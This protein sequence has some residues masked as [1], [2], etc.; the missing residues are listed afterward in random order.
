MRMLH[1]VLAAGGL[2]L[3]SVAWAHQTSAPPPVDSPGEIVQL[4]ERCGAFQVVDCA[5]EVLTGQPLHL[6][7]GSLAPQDGFGAGLAYVGHKTTD[8]WRIHWDADGL[9]STK[10][11]RVGW[12]G[13]FVHSTEAPT[14]SHV[15]TDM[16]APDTPTELPEHLVVTLT[17]QAISL[18]DVGFFGLG[19][20]TS[21]DGEV[22][23]GMRQTILGAAVVKPF[24]SS[25]HPTLYG[26]TNGRFVSIRAPA[27]APDLADS[28][29]F[30][31]L[32]E[33]VRLRPTF[34]RRLVELNYDVSFREYIAPADSTFTF[35]RLTVDLTHDVALHFP[36]RRRWPQ[37]ANGPDECTTGGDPKHPFDC[38][39][40]RKVE[41]T[42]EV[43][44][45]LSD[46]FTPAGHVVP[47]YLQPTLGG[48]DIN[49]EH[50]LASY[51]DY[52]FRAPNV[53][54]VRLGIEH[55]IFDLPIGV[56]ALVDTGRVALTRG[57]LTTGPWQNSVSAGLTV[58]AGGIPA[59][60]LLY[61]RGGS[62]GG[63]ASLLVSTTLLGGSSRP[64]LY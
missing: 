33:G 10:G 44:A 1:V 51:Q 61:A 5:S 56:I 28:R 58:R 8:A 20:S 63:H 15:G 16:P 64:S 17:A 11:W 38:T 26:E 50:A 32:A 43:R 52:R 23:F 29:T 46:A 18:D 6:T 42:V 40:T 3:P 48:A 60:S 41:G 59:L 24:T 27:T 9:A 39:I 47:F 19:P 22:F 37:D 2:L 62:E 14:T 54:F 57:A 25:W 7:I 53:M 21:P 55:S 13:K 49:G 12:Y 45:F 34:A 30:V 35:D 4:Q 36:H 31:Q